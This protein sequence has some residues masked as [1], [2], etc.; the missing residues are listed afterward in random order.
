MTGDCKMLWALYGHLWRLSE[1]YADV[2]MKF[3]LTTLFLDGCP[4]LAYG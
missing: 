2:S 3:N 1:V 4:K